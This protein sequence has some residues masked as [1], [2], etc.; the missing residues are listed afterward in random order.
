MLNEMNFTNIRDFMSQLD[1]VADVTEWVRTNLDDVELKALDNDNPFPN[2]GGDAYGIGIKIDEEPVIP[3]RSTSISTLITRADVSGK[4]IQRLFDADKLLF[5]KHINSYYLLKPKKRK[6]CLALV[7]D[8]KL[9]ALHSGSYSIIPLKGV[10]QSIEEYFA[11]NF[12]SYSLQNAYWS[13]EYSETNYLI[14][15]EY[16][17]KVY[18]T[19]SSK[20]FDGE[21]KVKLRCISSDVAEAAVRIYPYILVGNKAVPLA[22]TTATRHYGEANLSDVI[23]NISKAFVGFEAS[24]RSLNGLADVKISHTKNC[25]IKAYTAL[26]IPQKYAAPIAEK[27]ENTSSDALSI[28]ISMCECLEYMKKSGLDKASIMKYEEVLS[29]LITYNV[30]KWKEMDIPGNVAWAA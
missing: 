26:R 21:S 12:E 20:Y 5:C 3:L 11:D 17:K 16:F 18:N 4:G 27:Y 23:K 7:Q 29:K 19:L 2:F 9:S 10:F 15:D 14:E 13:W 28:Y 6:D 25:M 24:C 30:I 22:G 8:G 1:A